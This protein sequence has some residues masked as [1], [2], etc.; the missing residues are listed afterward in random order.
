MMA[1]KN[2]KSLVL[3]NLK[4]SDKMDLDRFL[5]AQN[6]MYH[7]AL[8][9][10][11]G[12]YKQSHWIWYIFPQLKGLGF[13]SNA[14][15]YGIKDAKEAKAYYEHPILSQRLKE[16]SHALL[17][18]DSSDPSEVMGYPDDLKLRSCMTLF[19]EV[20]RDPLF[21]QVLDKFF[22]GEEDQCTLHLLQTQ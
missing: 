18:L 14:E 3:Y 15:Y 8:S 16:I 9:E 11:K 5:K 12:G 20:T 21:K 19:Y 13:S 6:N 1:K 10:I 17:M 7:V 2:G 22:E 4:G